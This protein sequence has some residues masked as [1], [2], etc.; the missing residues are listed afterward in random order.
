MN[1]DKNNDLIYNE[2]FELVY[3]ELV[4][5]KEHDKNYTIEQMENLLQS[6]YDNEGNNW[7][8][9][10]DLRD[11]KQSATIAACEAVLAEW[12]SEIKDKRS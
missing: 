2:R 12:R 5:Q 11:M 7:T 4:Y 6:L 8:G 10:G 1:K 3:N 9:R